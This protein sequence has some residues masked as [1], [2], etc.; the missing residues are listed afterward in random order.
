MK[1]VWFVDKGAFA[2][3]SLEEVKKHIMDMPEHKLTRLFCSGED[4]ICHLSNHE[5]ISCIY[6]MARKD[7]KVRF[8]NLVKQS[9]IK[10]INRDILYKITRIG[11]KSF[12]KYNMNIGTT[13]NQS[14]QVEFNLYNWHG[15]F[16]F[17]YDYLNW[18]HEYNKIV[19]FRKT[20]ND[21]LQPYK[22]DSNT[23]MLRKGLLAKIFKIQ[24]ELWGYH[25]IDITTHDGTI[26][27]YVSM[28]RE[29]GSEFEFLKDESI[30]KWYDTFKKMVEY[31]NK[32]KFHL[33]TINDEIDDRC[34][35]HHYSI[36]DC[37]YYEDRYYH[38]FNYNC[39]LDV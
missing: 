4:Y 26:G 20:I 37:E 33:E 2:S 11:I 19:E 39:I 17:P 14:L 8:S 10:D 27:V 23:L 7:G 3:K 30:D 36:Q 12:D 34:R 5:P 18:K 31:V 13:C 21:E 25:G 22:T 1:D 9:E 29:V 28:Y 16:D 15:F 24:I 32:Y 6:F 35:R 38:L